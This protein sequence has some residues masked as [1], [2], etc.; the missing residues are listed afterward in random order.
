MTIPAFT[1]PNHLC[2]SFGLPIRMSR[3]VEQSKQYSPYDFGLEIEEAE[4]A[5]ELSALI[6]DCSLNQIAP[7]VD[8][9]DFENTY[10]FFLS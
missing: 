3:L 2:N 5:S 8:P 9:D 7:K 10:E 4:L 6:P 1:K